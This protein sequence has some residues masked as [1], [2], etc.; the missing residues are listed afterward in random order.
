M[1]LNIDVN[2]AYSIEQ[3]V[4][5]ILQIQAPS[6]ADQH[7]VS[8]TFDLGNPEHVGRIAGEA[9]MGDRVLLS[10]ATDFRFSYTAQIDVNRPALALEQLKAVAPHLLPGDAVRYLMPSRYCQ[11]DELQS[12]VAAEFGHLSG[13]ARIVAMRD[14]INQRYQYVPGSS[15][16]QTTAIDTFV[17]R[18]GVCRDF[19]HVLIALA[20]ASAIPARFVSVYAPHVT[21]QD[22]HAV[23][24]VF[25]DGTWHLVDAT[26]MADAS[27]I[28]RIGVGMDAAEVAFLSS[29][30][31][32]TMDTQTVSVS[33]AGS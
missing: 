32:M 3:P 10:T 17:Q 12:F 19:A 29:F 4:D 6:F 25:L 21:P 16:A 9:G 23:A 20:R 8:E 1:I 24:E 2:L 7:V 14:W 31:P 18:Q 33:I 28:A 5:L 22:F 30:G 11:S 15:T 27:D 26:G 13:G